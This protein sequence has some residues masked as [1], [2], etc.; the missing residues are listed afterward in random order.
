M[1]FA[2]RSTHPAKF[3]R[4]TDFDEIFPSRFHFHLLSLLV[5]I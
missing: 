3:P 1:G 2:A 4:N 5:V